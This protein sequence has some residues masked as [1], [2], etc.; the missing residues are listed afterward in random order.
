MMGWWNFR[1]KNDPNASKPVVTPPKEVAPVA[2]PKRA[3]PPSGSNSTGGAIA[4]SVPI[5]VPASPIG[6]RR[7]NAEGMALVE[8]FEGLDL[9][10][11]LDSVKVPTIGFGRIKYDD[12]SSVKMG[13]TCTRA[14]ADQWLQEDLEKDGGQYVRRYVA[15]A[16]NDDQY[17]AL[18]SFTFN[19]GA[20]RLH[21]L[22]AMGGE[23]EQI[24]SNMLHFDY[25]GTADNHLLGL[26]RRRRAE[27]ALFH[28]KP[29][30]P[31]ISWNP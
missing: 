20:G 3:A 15:H 17:A 19:R 23:L 8:Q 1:N 31:F 6:P 29:W 30:R 7:I 11:Y 27:Q 26:K 21:Q 9:H 4:P 14:Q 25:A 24:A 22:V 12:G 18:V 5:T 10:A 16:L 28:S 2:A 13:D